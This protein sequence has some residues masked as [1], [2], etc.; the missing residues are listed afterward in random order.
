MG[1]GVGICERYEATT[2]RKGVPWAFLKGRWQSLPP[3]MQ[4]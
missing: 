3:D 4:E 2:R 1:R